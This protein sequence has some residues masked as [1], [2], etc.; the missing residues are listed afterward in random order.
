MAEEKK[1][2]EIDLLA[3]EPEGADSV[4]SEYV[5]GSDNVLVEK[6][7]KEEPPVTTPEEKPVA[8]ATEKEPL[9]VL[10]E[11]KVKDGEVTPKV[12][13]AAEPQ[14]GLKETKG[15]PVGE[16]NL[17]ATIREAVEEHLAKTVKGV[18]EVKKLPAEDWQNRYFETQRWG[19]QVQQ[20]NQTLKQQVA[21]IEA[22]LGR[23][24]KKLREEGVEFNDPV[25]QQAVTVPNSTP[26]QQAVGT[27][28]LA[29][30][31]DFGSDP[32]LNASL[33]SADRQ[34]GQKV[35]DEYL[36]QGTGK[37]HQM[38]K[39]VG[40]S[41]WDKLSRSLDPCADAIRMTRAWEVSQPAQGGNGGNMVDDIVSQ[42]MQKIGVGKQPPGGV[43]QDNLPV[44]LD[45][46]RSAVGGDSKKK[47][48][49]EA[50]PDD[51]FGQFVGQR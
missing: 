35:V 7:P 26:P 37:F 2:A 22:R 30:P 11:D 44:G 20:E 17:E 28:P 29:P 51:F 42:I 47:A 19:T 46:I 12:S 36:S 49:V 14:A 1:L 18:G 27:P 5:G 8:T 43:K 38:V 50:K 32:R 39:E 24:N 16:A 9:A 23:A 25:P 21:D 34:F 3:P 40:P 6:K 15:E 45:A 48:D 10:P 41:T 33:D 13:K 31:P 4:F